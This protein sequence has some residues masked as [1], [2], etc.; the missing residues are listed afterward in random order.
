VSDAAADQQLDGAAEARASDAVAIVT[1]AG[2]GVGAATALALAQAGFS[3]ILA[4]R[5]IDALR[6]TA[7]RIRAAGASALAVICDVTDERSVTELF[8]TAIRERGRVDVLFNNAGIGMAD[9][10]LEQVTRDEWDRVIATNVTGVFLC[11]REA[12]RVMKLQQPIGGRIIN[13][14]SISA[15]V[16][17]PNSIAYTTA[18]HAVTG[19]TRSTAL[20]GR[21]FRI[22]CGQIDIG[23]A[24]TQ[25]TDSMRGPGALQPDGSRRQEPTI[26]AAEIARAV[27]YM[28][29]LPL[30][31]NVLFMTVMATAMPYVGRG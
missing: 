6:E 1:G 4:G 20:D 15:H 19:L 31:A 10:D 27:V 30:D 24:S 28:A 21:A 26:P 8:N 23:N 7:A 12:F 16:P 13:N 17:R 25:M 9:K 22:A 18:K 11:T 14:G 29:S 2:S 5:R 3:P